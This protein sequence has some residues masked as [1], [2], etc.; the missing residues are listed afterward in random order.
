MG[1]DT[2]TVALCFFFDRGWWTFKKPSY[3]KQQLRACLLGCA[4][5]S[6]GDELYSTPEISGYANPE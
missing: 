5:I 2:V 4:S 1:A 3:F 6:V